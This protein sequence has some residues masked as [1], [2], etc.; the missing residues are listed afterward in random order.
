MKRIRIR[1][2]IILSVIVS[3]SIFA[4]C[5]VEQ[6]TV[7]NFD[8]AVASVTKSTVFLGA[9]GEGEVEDG[10]E[11]FV[12][13]YEVTFRFSGTPDN[14]AFYSGE[15]GAEY[16]YRNRYYRD[17][18]S[19]MS[20]TTAFSGGNIPNTLRIMLSNDF[21]PPYLWAASIVNR[22]LTNAVVNAAT[23]T[24]ITERFRLPG[25]RLETGE[26]TTGEATIS[27]F[28]QDVPFFIGFWFDADKRDDE[29][30]SLGQWTFSNFQIRNDYYDG[31]SDY[32]VDN[33]LNNNWRKLD[34]ADTTGYT[35]S[36]NRIVVNGNV[37][38]TIV[39]EVEKEVEIDEETGETEWITEEEIE[40]IPTLRAQARVVSRPFYPLLVSA[41]KGVAIKSQGEYLYEYTYLYVN[42]PQESVRATFVAVNSLYGEDVQEVK[43]IEVVFEE[44]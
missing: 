13:V 18:I 39:R 33:V 21:E 3:V 43:E 26:H 8:A 1:I 44:R 28:H 9:E 15:E 40:Y 12:D 38:K 5:K 14:I 23:W 7:P 36:G 24:Y 2:R 11:A 41:D 22:D 4:S 17:G 16:K 32:Y 34:V 37:T 30:L 35:V 42:P 25:N 29:S 6:L 27:E 10:V 19:T 31:T 20:F